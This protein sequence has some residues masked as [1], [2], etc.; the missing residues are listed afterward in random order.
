MDRKTVIRAMGFASAPGVLR[1]LG[2]IPGLGL[3]ILVVRPFG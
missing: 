1:L 2:G 3:V